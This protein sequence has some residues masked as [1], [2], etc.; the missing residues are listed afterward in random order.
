[1]EINNKQFKICSILEP[2][3]KN[4]NLE[5]S[6]KKEFNNILDRLYQNWLENN[7]LTGI[8]LKILYKL[9]QTYKLN[10]VE[11]IYGTSYIEN[12][13]P[14]SNGCELHTL[15]INDQSFTVGTSREP[16]VNFNYGMWY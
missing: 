7:S 5:I 11:L 10:N 16:I 3:L 6:S 13:T 14:F 8:P 2:Y 4:E 15:N 1:M 9:L 12:P